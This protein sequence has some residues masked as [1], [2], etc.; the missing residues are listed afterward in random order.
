MFFHVQKNYFTT[1]RKQYKAT[2]DN[3]LPDGKFVNE[4]LSL[5]KKKNWILD[6]TKKICLTLWTSCSNL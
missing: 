5:F 6:S 4:M 3:P 1:K 2:A